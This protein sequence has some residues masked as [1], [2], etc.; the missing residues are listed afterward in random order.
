MKLLSK[1]FQSFV[2]FIL[3]C[4]LCLL[5]WF[6]PLETEGSLQHNW[7]PG[8]DLLL[9]SWTCAKGENSW[10]LD[11]TGHWLSSDGPEDEAGGRGRAEQIRVQ[12][13]S[14][15]PPML[16]VDSLLSFHCFYLLDTVLV[17]GKLE[18]TPTRE[19]WCMITLPIILRVEEGAELR[20]FEGL[21]AWEIRSTNSWNPKTEAVYEKLCHRHSWPMMVPQAKIWRINNSASFF[22]FSD[23]SRFYFS[24]T[25]VEDQWAKAKSS[26]QKVVWARGQIWGPMENLTLLGDLFIFPLLEAINKVKL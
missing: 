9:P 14:G 24:S 3:K 19:R 26:R 17:L 18:D 5:C 20:C 22:H 12:G 8:E 6:F 11:H 13:D 7:R 1:R 15:A 16:T 23:L 10:R 21:M 2:L 25:Y 4:V